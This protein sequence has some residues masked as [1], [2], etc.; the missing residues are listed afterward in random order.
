MERAIGAGDVVW[1]RGILT[2]GYGLCHGTAG[3]G[4][5]FLDLYRI[6]YDPKW[7][8]RAIKVR[9][10]RYFFSTDIDV[11]LFDLV[12]RILFGLWQTSFIQRTRLSLFAFR[13]YTRMIDRRRINVHC[14]FRFGWNDLFRC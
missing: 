2:K 9:W 5:V 4:Y 10:M 14:V 13:R 8:H 12:R 1:E 6:T 3:N 11:S 7:L